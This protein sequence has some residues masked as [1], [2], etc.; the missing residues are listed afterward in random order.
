[1]KDITPYNENGKRDGYW[2]VYYSN[3]NLNKIEYKI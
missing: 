3:G 2:E 1:M